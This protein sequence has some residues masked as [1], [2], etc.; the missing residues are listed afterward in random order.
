MKG[1]H[2]E[3]MGYQPA[4]SGIYTTVWIPKMLRGA[5]R[6]SPS[7][8]AERE[9]HSVALFQIFKKAYAH[10]FF[11]KEFFVPREE[12]TAEGTAMLFESS[13]TRSTGSTS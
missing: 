12:I 2:A 4:A 8:F 1:W 13:L 3:I 5:R 11:I 6:N 10:W 9:A 7:R